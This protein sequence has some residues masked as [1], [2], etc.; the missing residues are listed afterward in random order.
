MASKHGRPFPKSMKALFLVLLLAG[1]AWPART[2]IAKQKNFMSDG[3]AAAESRTGPA[4]DPS[5]G[6]HL[7]FLG[8]PIDGTL[9][10]FVD[11]IRA[12][13]YEV[14]AKEED[15]VL[16]KGDFAAYKDCMI[17]VSALPG[18]DLVNRV[19]VLFPDQDTWG[20]LSGDY[21]YFKELLTEKYGE[22]VESVE[23]FH[24]STSSSDY[25]KMLDVRMNDCKYLS[26]FSADGGIIFLYI[27]NADGLH[28]FV[29]LD[30]YDAI[31]T[32]ETRE[33]AIDDL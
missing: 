16:L 28:T 12:K 13:G 7:R 8:V 30:H 32:G 29:R 2:Q 21:F 9:D 24:G 22:P 14:R 18:K 11:A 33:R 15:Y 4:D 19:S 31:N 3:G 6:D 10:A 26:S 17:G 1:S 23:E 5:D 20:G 27:S 25:G